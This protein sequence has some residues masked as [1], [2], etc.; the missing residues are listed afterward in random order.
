MPRPAVDLDGDPDVRERDIDVPALERQTPD[1]AGDARATQQLQQPPLEGR[2]RPVHRRDQ[3]PAGPVHPVTA[4]PAGVRRLQVG[5]FHVPLQGA[6]E[7]RRAV[8]VGG[9][10]LQDGQAP[11]GHPDPAELDPVHRREILGAHPDL[12]P[13]D[14]AHVPRNGDQHR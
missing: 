1:D 13:P 8:V 10:R 3:Q 11:A 2:V 12:G 6:V 7:E 4:E 9:G 14:P 5:R